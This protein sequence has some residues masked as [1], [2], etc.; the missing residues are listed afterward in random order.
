[1]LKKGAHPFE[2]PLDESGFKLAKVYILIYF[3]YI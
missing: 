1:M 2:T 3:L